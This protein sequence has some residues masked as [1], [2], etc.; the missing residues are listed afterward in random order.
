M[1]V[2]ILCGI[3][4]PQRSLAV[5][6]VTCCSSKSLVAAGERRSRTAERLSARTAPEQEADTR[7]VPAAGSSAQE[8]PP[9]GDDLRVA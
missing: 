4:L 9:A 2:R 7:S 6:L 1:N 8:L 3:W 5:R